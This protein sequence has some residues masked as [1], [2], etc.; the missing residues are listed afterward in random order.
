MAAD[1]PGNRTFAAGGGQ[2]GRTRLDPRIA[3]SLTDV[4]RHTRTI[5][6]TPQSL[7]YPV[8]PLRGKKVVIKMAVGTV[9]WFNADK[10]YGFIAP[11]GGGNDLFVHI[12]AIVDAGPRGQAEGQKVEFEEGPGRK[13]P[14]ATNVRPV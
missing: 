6:C 12:S 2:I 13:G 4:G 11:D 14:Q 7:D 3:A 5:L 10:G 9:K 8:H 1:R